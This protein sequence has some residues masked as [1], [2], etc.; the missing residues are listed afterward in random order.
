MNQSHTSLAGDLLVQTR[1][2]YKTLVEKLCE[3]QALGKSRCKLLTL[4]WV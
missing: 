4:E 3:E 1:N 2:S